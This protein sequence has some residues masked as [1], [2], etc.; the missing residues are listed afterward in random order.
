MEATPVG[1][2]WAGTPV[3]LGDQFDVTSTSGR[4]K[5]QICRCRVEKAPPNDPKWRV[6]YV[7]REIETGIIFGGLKIVTNPQQALTKITPDQMV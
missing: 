3:Y 4:R 6:P 5:G 2:D 1:H 7:L